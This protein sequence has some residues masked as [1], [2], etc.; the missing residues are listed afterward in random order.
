M[1]Y[2]ATRGTDFAKEKEL[3][4]AAYTLNVTAD[5]VGTEPGFFN[6]ANFTGYND[7]KAALEAIGTDDVPAMRAAIEDLAD[8]FEAAQVPNPVVDGNYYVIYNDNHN[9]SDLG[10][11]PKAMYINTDNKDL[12]WG[13]YSSEDLKFVFQAIAGDNENEF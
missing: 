2:E 1:F 7:A 6:E 11:T 5:Q 8:A 4:L 10:N 9:I 12:Y 3:A 13:E